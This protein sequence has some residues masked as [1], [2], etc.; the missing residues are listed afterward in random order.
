ML[1][2]DYGYLDIQHPQNFLPFPCSLSKRAFKRS[3]SPAPLDCT[4]LHLNSH[5]KVTWWWNWTFIINHTVQSNVPAAPLKRSWQH[6]ERQMMCGEIS[7]SGLCDGGAQ[8]NVVYWWYWGH[9]VHSRAQWSGLE[10]QSNSRWG[11]ATRKAVTVTAGL[12][13]HPG[14]M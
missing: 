12:W 13:P 7:A 1:L 10:L 14:V 2:Q 3:E 11:V 9:T 8:T 6:R 5:E 4:K